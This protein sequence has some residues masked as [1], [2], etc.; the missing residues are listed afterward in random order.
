MTQNKSNICAP[1]GFAA[2][3]TYSGICDHRVKLDLA[4]IVSRKDCSIVVANADG[5]QQSTGRAVLFH[6]GLALPEGQ[7]GNEI[8]NEAKAAVSQYI[9]VPENE[10][11][12]IAT[13]LTGGY[14]RPSLLVNSVSTLAA[15]L[16]PYHASLVE[17]VMDNGG[18]LL[19]QDVTFHAGSGECV[20]GGILSEG[21]EEQ[22][23]L[24]LI[25]TD[26][27]AT[28]EQIQ[29][30]LAT[31]MEAF[32]LADYKVVV[33]ANGLAAAASGKEGIASLSQAMTTLLEQI[34][35]KTALKL[36]S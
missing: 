26:M 13:G 9:D 27:A 34:G 19:S 21:T 4:M 17:S 14:F 33:M 12:F 20:M 32:D 36:I 5:T 7:R 18:S 28:T 25:T 24:C 3:G 22:P 1:Q 8:A 29:E 31:S 35:V 30:A 2:A 11:S 15:G 16:S 10:I 6:N 23:G